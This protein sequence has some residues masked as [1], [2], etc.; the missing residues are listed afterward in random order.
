MIQLFSYFRSSASFRVR[1]ALHLKG[2]NFEE[3]PINLL[4]AEQLNP[5]Y[6][7][8]N[9]QALVPTIKIEDKIIS[10]S[11]AIIEYL[12]DIFPKPALLPQDPYQKALVNAFSL[13]IA[14]DIHPL[15][16]IGVLQF[17]LK[18][19]GLSEEQKNKWYQ[20]WIAKGLN[21]LELKLAKLD[22]QSAFCF[23]D[24]PTLADICLV[25]QMYNARR[26]H[27][28]ISP[29]KILNKIDA[30]CQTHPAF[31]KAWPNNITSEREKTT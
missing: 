8:L 24:S 26:F 25:P 18:E 11:I 4:N 29:Y 23:G 22:L 14:A 2:L 17:L 28:D 20:H 31:I 6:Q 30:H 19:Y 1:I 13:A 12:E 10:Q 15:N 3:I 9:P 7:L 21:A 27:C 16:N 5:E